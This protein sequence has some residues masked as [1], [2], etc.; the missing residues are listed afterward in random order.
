M[1]TFKYPPYDLDYLKDN[2]PVWLISLGFTSPVGPKNK[3]FTNLKK[4]LWKFLVVKNYL[5]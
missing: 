4:E 1:Y 2:F 5:N 3:Q